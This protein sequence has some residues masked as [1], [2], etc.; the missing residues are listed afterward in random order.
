MN[1]CDFDPNRV[2]AIL[3]QPQDDVDALLAEFAFEAL[4]RGVRVGGVVQRNPKDPSGRKLGMNAVDLAT[5]RE[6]PLCQDLGPGSTACK[7]NP[8]RLAEASLA[9]REAVA[10]GVDLVVVNKF[11]KQEAE[12]RGLRDEI[13]AAIA[14]DIP[15]LTA[16]PQKCFDD[17]VAFTGDF[18]VTLA[19]DPEAVRAWW[20]NVKR[21]REVA[22]PVDF[23]SSAATA[24][25]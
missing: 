20:R 4:A 1:S 23:A 24:L 21:R 14:A 9:V 15:V 22:A 16:T 3:Y 7:L 17:W 25:G 10:R 6:I 2:A 13:A 5:G 8:A 11:A 12:G 18:G 19:C